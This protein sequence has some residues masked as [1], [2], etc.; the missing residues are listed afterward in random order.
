MTASRY[1]VVMNSTPVAAILSE[2]EGTHAI[3]QGKGKELQSCIL[4]KLYL[5]FSLYIIY[6]YDL[7]I[8]DVL[9]DEVL[10]VLTN[11]SSVSL[12]L[13]SCTQGKIEPIELEAVALPNKGGAESEGPIRYFR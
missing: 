6:N 5:S 12:L 4:R 1:S 8:V 11:T 13:L 9:P 2:L 3:D 7:V 10:E